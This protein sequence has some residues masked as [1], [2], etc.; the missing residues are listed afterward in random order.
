MRTCCKANSSVRLR[1]YFLVL[2]AKIIL[3]VLTLLV[4]G[5][6]SSA[7]KDSAITMKWQII[8][9][10]PEVGMAT[11]QITLTDSTEQSVTGAQIELEGNMSHPGMQPVMASAEEVAPGEYEAPLE[12]TMAGQWFILVKSTLSDGS[13]IEKQINISQVRSE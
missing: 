9:D 3:L 10:P 13:V 11:I 7:E 1:G 12:F 6:Q 5:C 2:S 8:P 4:A